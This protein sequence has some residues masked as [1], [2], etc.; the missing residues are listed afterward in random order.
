[1][2]IMRQNLHFKRLKFIV[3]SLLL[4][5]SAGCEH[6][7]IDDLFVLHKEIDLLKDSQEDLKRRLD[8]LN[9]SILTIQA[10]IDVLNSGYYVERIEPVM[11]D[12]VEAGYTFFFTNG[13]EITIANGNDGAD[14]HTP[15][16]GVTLIDGK[17][18]WTLD[19][20]LLKD[21]A[22]NIIPVLSEKMIS[23]LFSISNGYWYL[24]FDG[25]NSWRLLGQATGVDGQYGADGVQN[26]IRVDFSSENVA[27][28]VLADGTV[29]SI[30]RRKSIKLILD[31]GDEAVSIA[32]R[33]T[34]EVRYQ[35]TDA[36]ENTVVN[37]SSDGYYHA[38]VIP[39]AGLA[40]VIRITCPRTYSDGFVNVL[41]FEDAGIVDSHL[42]RFYEK[43]M[44]FSEGME[45]DVPAEGGT[46]TVP[47]KVNFPYHLVTDQGSEVWLQISDSGYLE[48]EEGSIVITASPNEGIARTGTVYIVPE[49]SEQVYAAIFITQQSMLCTIERG[50]FIIPFEGGTVLCGITTEYQFRAVVPVA[51]NGWLRADV[52]DYGGGKYSVAIT[53]EP[54]PKASS[55]SSFVDIVSKS[56]GRKMASIRI[57]QNGRNLDLE[58]SMVFV[59]NPNFSNDFTAF[60]PIDINSDFDCFVDWGDGTGMRYRN[61][62]DFDSYPQELRNV[63][64]KYE[65][66]DV[67]QRFEVVVSGTVTSLCADVIPLAFR[68]SVT[69][70]KQ[71]GKTGLTKMY[72][73]FAGFAGLTTLHLDETGAFEN[74]TSFE[75]SFAEC[76][77]LTTISEHLFDYAR[78]ATSFQGTF[79]NCH[80]LALIPG[81]LF[82]Q[83]TAAR[84]FN[85]LFYNCKSL[86]T[87]PEDLFVK[88]NEVE[89][90]R[91]AFYDCESLREVPSGLFNGNPKVTD[92]FGLFR[93]C[94]AL[95]SV[96]EGIFD[97]NIEV[98][99]VGQLFCDCSALVTIPSTLFD[100]QQRLMNFSWMFTN[101]NELRTESPWT[102]VDGEK[103]HLYERHLHPDIFVF[104][105]YHDSCFGGC[106]N[107]TDYSEIP[108]SWK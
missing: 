62:D 36:T 98:T 60:L 5:F 63:H 32:G 106:G 80:R 40:G 78:S 34:I 73:A 104:P 69:E 13:K 84:S 48:S 39:G 57:L 29:I 22:G 4:V 96:P 3:L 94:R 31:S 76:P 7:F 14:G 59:V 64:H 90:F 89:F 2:K 93:G 86:T 67:G 37:V 66:I 50:S 12:G 71:W 97:S 20:N 26:F 72:R 8:N 24:S 28:F 68:S 81:N 77:R 44:T 43:S 38:T 19:G 107:L 47:Y 91:Y 65:G 102:L 46:V 25:G 30:P 79:S 23:P 87:V 83:A 1:M 99:N 58:Y 21:D 10:I 33:E 108:D 105:M 101:C 17:Y 82:R 100:H 18:Y 35:L 53:A 54:N 88:C 95:A 85:W 92:F 56:D 9:E 55:R 6:T 49:N 70:V 41:V 16:V 45:F 11:D 61:E 74:V 15:V 52:L 27:V 51:D 75:Y 42:I 103:V